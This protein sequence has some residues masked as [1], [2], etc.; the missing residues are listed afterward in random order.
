[1]NKFRDN[2]VSPFTLSGR[3]CKVVASHAAVAHSSPAEFVLIY[4]MHVAL[5]EYCP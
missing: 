1:M 4:T 2:Y 5:R 3:M